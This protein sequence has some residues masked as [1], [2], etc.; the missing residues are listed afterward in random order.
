MNQTG[1][2]LVD[3]IVVQLKEYQPTL[4]FSILNHMAKPNKPYDTTPR[5]DTG[6]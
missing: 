3:T 6:M 1:F 5:L 2:L 4:P